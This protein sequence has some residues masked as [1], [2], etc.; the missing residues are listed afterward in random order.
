MT[1]PSV[2]EC[3]DLPM[4]LGEGGGQPTSV[5]AINSN[6]GRLVVASFAERLVS[7][8][9]N[10]KSVVTCGDV[11]AGKQVT[12]DQCLGFRGRQAGDI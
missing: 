7:G 10:V 4:L 2:I 6:P 3:I 9:G 1:W 5:C 8:E 12:F 11:E